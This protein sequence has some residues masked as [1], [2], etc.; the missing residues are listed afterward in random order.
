MYMSPKVSTNLG[1]HVG[2][3]PGQV[4]SESGQPHFGA[5]SALPWWVRVLGGGKGSTD[6]VESVWP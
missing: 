1:G 2:P 5:N 3:S 6:V 4:N